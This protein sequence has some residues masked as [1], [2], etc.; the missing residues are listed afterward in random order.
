[1]QLDLQKILSEA[2]LLRL[3]MPTPIITPVKFY[4]S[5]RT[6]QIK[7]PRGSSCSIF[8]S[9][10]SCL[11]LTNWQ[12]TP[13]TPPYIRNP[14]HSSTISLDLDKYF[15][16]WRRQINPLER[17]LSVIFRKVSKLFLHYYVLRVSTFIGLASYHINTE[18]SNNISTLS[19][20]RQ[21]LHHHPFQS[22][23]NLFRKI[24][25]TQPRS[26]LKE[27]EKHHNRIFQNA[28]KSYPYKIVSNL[29]I[30]KLIE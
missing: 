15:N 29:T 4:L 20:A 25:L 2:K 11:L 8:S 12:F 23:H 13:I 24:I 21:T 10:K 27:T 7:V 14:K 19:Q 17:D 22:V 9:T 3:K 26:V 6:F 30:I 1:M 28:I 18:T 5:E 16:R